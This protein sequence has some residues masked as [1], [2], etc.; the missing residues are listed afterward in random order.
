MTDLITRYY[1]LMGNL[2]NRVEPSQ[3]DTSG[4]GILDNLVTHIPVSD[5]S[6]A[7]GFAVVYSYY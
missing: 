2:K 6:S 7:V 3:V 1:L 5:Y 4:R